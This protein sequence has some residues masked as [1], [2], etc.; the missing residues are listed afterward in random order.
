M[1]ITEILREFAPTDRGDDDREDAP[2][3]DE[4]VVLANRWWNNTDDQERIAAVLQ[5]MGWG[6]SQVESEDDAVMLQNRDGTTHFIS[7]DE[8]DPDLF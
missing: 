1:K 3:P 5:S 7:A 4:L 6:I 8:F 2:V